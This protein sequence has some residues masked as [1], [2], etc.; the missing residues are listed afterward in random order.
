MGPPECNSAHG[1]W[2]TVGIS[3]RADPT[4]VLTLG[5]HKTFVASGRASWGPKGPSSRERA[6]T[7]TRVVSD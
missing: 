5:Q 4:L 2:F 7:A 6:L 1:P 3:K